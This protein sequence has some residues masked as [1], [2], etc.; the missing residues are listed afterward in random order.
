MKI[1]AALLV[2]MFISALAQAED[3]TCIDKLLPFSRHSGLHQMTK[4]DWSDS[5]DILD[6]E[7]ASLALHALVERKLLCK[8]GEVEVK[9]QPSCQT[10]HADI[11]QSN[12]CYLFTNLGYF[13]LSKDSGK[14]INFIFSKDKRFS[15]PTEE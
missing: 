13:I 11:P 1:L 4:D 15:S 7:T 8:K 6:S 10:F 9:L 12:V 3:L 2:M 5:R 14:N